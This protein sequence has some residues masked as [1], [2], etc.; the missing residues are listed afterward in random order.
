ML[1]ILK[2]FW[3]GSFDARAFMA[4][5][6]SRHLD[7][8]EKRIDL[9]IIITRV[10][11]EQRE[12]GLKALAE[13]CRLSEDPVSDLYY[14][15]SRVRDNVMAKEIINVIASMGLDRA[16]V[17][18]KLVRIAERP[19]GNRAARRLA[20][21]ICISHKENRDRQYWQDKATTIHTYE[22]TIDAMREKLQSDLG[23]GKRLLPMQKRWWQFW[24]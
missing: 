13:F 23:S 4:T 14:L 24:K 18:N 10:N 6:E 1:N 9:T 3:R 7:L 21:D 15:I 12:V 22:D 17:W 11:A 19:S 16:D 8:D 5:I 2:I 20:R